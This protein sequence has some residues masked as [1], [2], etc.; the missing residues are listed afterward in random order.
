MLHTGP[1]TKH[2]HTTETTSTIAPDTLG[3]SA[4]TFFERILAAG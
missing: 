3:V 2:N 4:R 1:T